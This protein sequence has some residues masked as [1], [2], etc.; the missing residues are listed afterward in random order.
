MLF[1]ASPTRA[2][3]RQGV[4]FIMNGYSDNLSVEIRAAIKKHDLRTVKKLAAKCPALLQHVTPHEWPII[5]ECMSCSCVDLELLELFVATGGDVNWRT[6]SGVS[7][8]YPAALLHERGDLIAFLKSNGA[9]MS[10]YEQG[11]ILMS[12]TGRDDQR[13]RL[14]QFRALCNENPNFVHEVGDQGV[15]LLYYAVD[16]LKFEF[17]PLL[18]EC[19]SNPN[20]ITHGGESPLA[21]QAGRNPGRG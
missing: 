14:D 20:T 8:V 4:E 9:H 5:H 3:S 15:T 19:G 11:V 6:P 12:E 1:P 17:V 18:L 7:L 10:L 2:V 21:R 13:K 16:Q